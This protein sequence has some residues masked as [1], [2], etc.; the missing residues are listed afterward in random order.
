M[1]NAVIDFDQFNIFQSFIRLVENI[2][3][4]CMC[5]LRALI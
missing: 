4:I 5:N 2:M 1:K 3:N